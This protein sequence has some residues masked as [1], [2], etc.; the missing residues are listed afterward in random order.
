MYKKLIS[1]LNLDISHF[2]GQFW[3]KG[4]KLSPKRK[5]SEYLSNQFPIQSYKLKLR[6]IKE[7]YFL[8]KCSNCNLDSWLDNP[9]PLELDHKN[10]NNLDNSL[11]N[12]RLLCPNCHA[13]TPNYRGKNKCHQRDSNPHA[14]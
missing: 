9:I 11:E 5:L 10:G 6:L 7:G 1:N 2:T 13:L 8:P 14:R 12:L 3:S 4:K